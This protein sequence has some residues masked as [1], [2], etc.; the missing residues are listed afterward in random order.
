M[1]RFILF[2]ILLLPALGFAECKVR[3]GNVVFFDFDNSKEE[4]EGAKQV[5]DEKCQNF[6]VFKSEK[7]ARATLK[8]IESSGEEISSMILSGHH[9]FGIFWGDNFHMTIGG[10]NDLMDEFPKTKDSI[11]NLYLWGCYTNN[12]DK[13]DRWLKGLPKLEYVFGYTQKAP[14]SKQ[15]TGV[16]YLKSAMLHQGELEKMD[17]LEKVKNFLDNKLVPGSSPDFQF[18]SA[19]I[20]GKAKCDNGNY[21]DFYYYVDHIEGGTKSNIDKYSD[22]GQCDGA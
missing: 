2:F 10:I 16:D 12:L 21:K 15:M 22:R 13:L 20:Y 6:Y 8:N 3:S 18:V 19:A 1:N 4:I 14:L 7:E 17:S 9:K 11:K 5:A